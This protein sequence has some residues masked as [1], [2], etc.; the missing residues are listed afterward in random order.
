MILLY[1]YTATSD[2]GFEL[3]H[4]IR[5]MCHHGDVTGCVVIG[6][7]PTWYTGEHY[8][9]ADIP[10]R[11]EWSIVKKVMLCPHEEVLYCHDDIYALEKIQRVTYDSGL[12]VQQR[13]GSKHAGRVHAT[14]R[15]YPK[16]LMFDNHCPM[17]INVEL[18]EEA[19]SKVNWQKGDFL[20][21]SI[22][23]NYLGLLT[24]HH[25][26]CKLR[27]RGD[28]IKSHWKFFSTNKRTA[29]EVNLGHMY[30]NKSPYEA[31]V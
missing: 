20:S 1:P 3:K 10:G 22:Y 15:V 27:H 2:D 29:R 26:D 16:G 17:F 30:P 4:S 13:N 18:Y 7:K 6:D 28:H 25:D 11:K 21:K 12:L 9:A 19:H 14:I 31:S 5:S 24:V 23:G 8:G